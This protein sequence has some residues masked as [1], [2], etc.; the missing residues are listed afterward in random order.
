MLLNKIFN[1]NIDKNLFNSLIV[2][3]TLVSNIISNIHVSAVSFTGSDI[4]GSKVAK[5]CGQNIKKTV[6]ELGGSDP[7][8][9]LEDADMKK[10]INGA[11]TSRMINNGQS[12]IAAKRFIVNEKIHDQF[13]IELKNKVEKLVIGDPLNK[14]TQVGP[15]A[16]ES[17]LNELDK[18]I[19]ESVHM[20]ASIIL[21]GSK[22]KK[23]GCF[24]Y[25]TIISNI[26]KD[27]PVYYQET[28][29][30]IFTIIKVKSNDEAIK[31][32][33]DSKYGLGGSIWSKDE[34]K[35]FNIATQIQTGCIFINGFTRSDPQLPFGGIK[36]S[37]YGKELS[38]YGI[39]EF[40]NSKTIVIY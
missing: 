38:K 37:G 2:D 7:F 31:I 32:A 1:K 11:I 40:V 24:Y 14:Q 33:N 12:C 36:K 19:Q 21:G 18:Q 10:C 16:T 26:S 20:G 17:I 34:D 23:E 4:A 13:L 3:S 8:I 25:P 29:G 39:R 5:Y 6:L 30:P 35:A 15:L 9:V 22:I 28:F 27:M